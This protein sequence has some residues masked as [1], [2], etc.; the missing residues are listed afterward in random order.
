[1]KFSSHCAREHGE[2]RT[3]RP[4]V[5]PIY[6][7]TSFDFD[8]LQHG[9]DV[10]SGT[11]PGH[12][13]SRFGNPT[14]DAVADKLAA[15][16]GYELD[17]P[18]GLLF[19]SGMAAIATLA[20]ALFRPG[21]KILTQWNIYGGTTS[22]FDNVLDRYQIGIERT[23]LADPDALRTALRDGTVR[24]IYLET[25]ANPTLACLDIAAISAVAHE[26]DALVVVDNTF[27]TPAL[28][29]PLALG[30]DY[31][32]HST[33]KYLNGHGTGIAGVLVGT[34][35]DQMRG[36]VTDTLRLLGTNCSP[37]EAW[38]VHNGLK[39]LHLRMERHGANAQR[40]AEFLVARPEVERVNY[41]GLSDHPQH[42]LA[43]RQMRNFGGMLSFELHGGLAAGERFVDR[44]RFCTLTPTLGDVDTLVL[45]PA[46][47][48][49]RG[50]DPATRRRFGIT[51][52]LI[53][54]SVGV[55]DAEDIIADL[56]QAFGE[57]PTV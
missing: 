29:R 28:Q 14:V 53:R 36:P 47:M 15:L 1:M 52:G 8:S 50:V 42:A 38:L 7:A 46:S 21:D 34:D 23:D 41:P 17:A 10:F 55:E 19:S 13:Y 51:D 9:I 18:A 48:S 22:L 32:L 3:T 11:T 40:V 26:F 43:R 54:L 4:H 33:T 20:L 39:T 44:L 24:M 12:L 27:C 35:A 5:L 45:H 6:A 37:F 57:A 2:P 16:E 30:A 49:H 31:V 56:A 25:P